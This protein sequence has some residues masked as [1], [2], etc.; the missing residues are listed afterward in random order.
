[1]FLAPARRKMVTTRF[2]RA[3]MIWGPLPV[4]I[5]ERSSSKSRSRIQCSRSS[6]AQW[7]RAAGHRRSRVRS[8]RPPRS[9]AAAWA[10]ARCAGPPTR[11]PARRRR[12]RPA[13]A[14][15]AGTWT[16]TA[17]ARSPRPG[18]GSSSVSAA[19]SA[20]A[21]NERAPASTAHTASA[22]TTTSRCRI[23]RRWRGSVTLASSFRPCA[24]ERP[25]SG[26]LGRSRGHRLV[27]MAVRLVARS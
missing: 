3:A 15:S 27:P 17:H 5:W 24:L 8:C 20:I 6:M 18:Q 19:H 23:P 11:L 16:P 9:P 25:T 14:R 12:P 4:R 13:A 21:V 10:W 7:P 2:R 1:M 26:A 22:K